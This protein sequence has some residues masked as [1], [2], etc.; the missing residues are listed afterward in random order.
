MNG[1]ACRL[2]LTLAAITLTAGCASPPGSTVEQ[3]TST[4]VA[5]VTLS[6]LLSA[7][8]PSL[9]KHEPG[10]LV[11]GQLPNQDPR[12]GLVGVAKKQQ[13]DY[14]VTFGDLTGDGVDDGALVTACSAGGV[15][16]PATVQLYSAGPTRLGGVDLSDVTHGREVV[17]G[18]SIAD[19]VVHV[20]WITQGPHDAECCGTV[21]M[22]GDLR[23]DGS[24][25][26]V[27]NVKQTN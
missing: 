21:H 16:W 20:S 19:G 22:A 15:P 23:W 1:L 14:W 6:D 3:H 17:T 8:V 11:N 26:N 25:V 2:A 18:L 5:A 27:E 9:C 24:K 12:F 13:A 4:P 7:P 10:N